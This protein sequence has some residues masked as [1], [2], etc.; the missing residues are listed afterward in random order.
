MGRTVPIDDD[1]PMPPERAFGDEAIRLHQAEAELE[2]LRARSGDGSGFEHWRLGGQQGIVRPIIE[3]LL[4]WMGVRD[5]R[6]AQ[7][8]AGSSGPRQ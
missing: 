8:L 1:E 4:A 2:R 3:F 7:H 5:R 6:P